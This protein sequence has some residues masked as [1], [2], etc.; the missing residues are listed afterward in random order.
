MT[1]SLHYCNMVLLY[2]IFQLVNKFSF[3]HVGN[4][5]H[6]WNSGE[7]IAKVFIY[8][9]GSRSKN[10]SYWVNGKVHGPLAASQLAKC[11]LLLNWV[12]F[13]DPNLINKNKINLIIIPFVS[14]IWLFWIR[15]Y[16]DWLQNLPP[17]SSSENLCSKLQYSIFYARK[18]AW[19][20][21]AFF[22]R[23]FFFFYNTKTFL[24]CVPPVSVS[25][26][27]NLHSIF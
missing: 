20:S 27:I 17:L 6:A 22:Y 9:R 11:I 8:D 5:M 23:I 14:H 18:L 13:R 2:L 25:K 12:L 16:F 7:S 3:F 21:Y 24:P 19:F 10:V 1:K 4:S 15:T 26:N